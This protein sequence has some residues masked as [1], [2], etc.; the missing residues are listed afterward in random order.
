MIRAYGWAASHLGEVR[1]AVRQVAEVLGVAFGEVERVLR[2]G[3]I[4]PTPALPPPVQCV[5]AVVGHHD[6][7]TPFSRKGRMRWR[8][9]RRRRLDDCDRPSLVLVFIQKH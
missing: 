7:R 4:T 3:L 2:R 9:S 1:D 8:S 6:G 5:L